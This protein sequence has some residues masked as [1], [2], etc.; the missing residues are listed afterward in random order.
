MVMHYTLGG[1]GNHGQSDSL[2]RHLYTLRWQ[3]VNHVTWRLV[4]VWDLSFEPLE[5]LLVGKLTVFHTLFPWVSMCHSRTLWNAVSGFSCVC[6]SQRCAPLQDK[7]GEEKNNSCQVDYSA[8]HVERSSSCHVMKT[9]RSMSDRSVP[10]LP[11]PISTFWPPQ[12]NLSTNPD[13]RSYPR[14]IP[15]VTSASV[16][17]TLHFELKS[18]I[19]FR[20]RK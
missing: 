14:A 13:W 9:P 18:S 20:Y 4:I 15:S 12:E 17:F 2:H 8:V 1:R 7:S 19:P 6:S 16:S 10:G 3:L 11:S 5:E